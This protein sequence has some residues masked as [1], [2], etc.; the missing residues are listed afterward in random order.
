[1]TRRDPQQ[2]HHPDDRTRFEESANPEQAVDDLE[3]RVLG[4]RHDQVREEPDE[5][6]QASEPP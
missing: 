5:D 3:R 2:R 1:M 4:Q 6:D